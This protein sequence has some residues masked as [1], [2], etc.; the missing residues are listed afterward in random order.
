MRIVLLVDSSSTVSSTFT[1]FRAGLN[2]FLDALAGEP[3]VAII[4]TGG[5]FR[6]R[7]EPTTDRTKLQAA[8]NSFAADGGG[9]SFLDVLLEADRRFLKTA[10]DRRSVFVILTTDTGASVADPRID[11]YNKF[12]SDFRAR[13]GQAHAIVITSQRSGVMTQI[14]QNLT[15]NTDGFF[16]TVGIASAVPKLMKMIAE[17]ISADQ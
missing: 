7:A 10:S 9:N 11:A 14:V 6:I 3:E 8:A 13:G 15:H 1:Q 12:M 5:Q 17:R 4:S 16:E 2:A